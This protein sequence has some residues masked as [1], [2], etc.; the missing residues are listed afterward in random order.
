MIDRLPNELNDIIFNMYWKDIY[1][2]HVLNELNNPKELYDK[3]M[4]FIT[5]FGIP[6]NKSIYPNNLLFYLQQFNNEINT[7]FEN[8]N[9]LYCKQNYFNIFNDLQN[10]DSNAFNSININYRNIC[11]FIVCKSGNSRYH[12]HHYFSTIY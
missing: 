8:S 11:R 7:L 6:I 2:T 10:N 12:V 9:T 4:N 3:I 5:K 1:T